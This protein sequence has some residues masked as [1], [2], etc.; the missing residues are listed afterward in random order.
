MSSAK[1]V[2]GTP[3]HPSQPP[4]KRAHTAFLDG[5][6]GVAAVF[7]VLHHSYLSAFPGYP[8]NTGPW[9]LG[10]MLLGHFAVTLFIV[11]SG[12]S[13]TLAVAPNDWRLV[14]GPKRF[15]WRR[16]W[17]IVPAYWAALLLSELILFIPGGDQP[18]AR[19]TLVHGLLLQNVVGSPTPNGTFWSIAPEWQIY[20]LFPLLLIALRYVKPIVLAIGV[21]VVVVSGQLASGFVEVLAPYSHMQTQFLALFVFGMGAA[22]Y[23]TATNVDPR[24]MRL[25]AGT[26][27]A[28]TVAVFVLV[29]Y[30]GVLTNLYWFDLMTG[31]VMAVL[32]VA[33]FTSVTGFRHVRGLLARPQLVF[34][35][36]FAYSIYL[37]HAPLLI[38]WDRF[39]IDPL[40]LTGMT[41][42]LTTLLV[43]VPVVL[44]FAYG[45]HLLAERP[46][47]RIR[48]RIDAARSARN[49]VDQP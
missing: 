32:L 9:Y 5:L 17:R 14:G 2:I 49:A 16:F 15:F 43:A 26:L 13:L 1:D 37:I 46:A 11:L 45:F 28:A 36:L 41:Q 35:G 19:G 40:G 3:T 34:M 12:F 21:T 48:N 33:L 27:T 18:S 4:A 42:Y 30:R 47:L 20:F 22:W 7:V 29:G 23:T 6:R 38:L 24:R 44:L 8:D 39:V 31:F 25:L 10:P